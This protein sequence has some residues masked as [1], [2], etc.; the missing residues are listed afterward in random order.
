M[1][2][3]SSSASLNRAGFHEGPD[4][5]KLQTYIKTLQSSILL[6]DVQ[7]GVSDR[8]SF[9]TETILGQGAQRIDRVT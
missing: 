7:S 1:K 6:P 5:R 8:D 4:Y 9:R 2:L 3:S